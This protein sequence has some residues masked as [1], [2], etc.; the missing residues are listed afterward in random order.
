M[1]IR[2]SSKS[3]VHQTIDVIVDD[4]P[5]AYKMI[6]R[7]D[8]LAK[9]NRYFTIDR[10]HLWLPYKCQP[11]KIKVERKVYMK[12]TINGLND[13]N[14]LVMLSNCILG[15]FFFHTFFGEL[16]AKLSPLANSDKQF[17][18]LHTTQ[19]VDP[20]CTIADDCTK[21]DSNNCTYIVSISNNFSLELTDSYIWTLYFDGSRNKEGESVGCLLIH[22]HGNKIMLAFRLEFN[23]NNNVAEYEALMQGLRKALDLQVKCIEVFGNSKINCT[24]NHL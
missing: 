7:K 23:C 1:M 8:R 24:L 6:L 16:E 12:H 15:N 22:L 14:E 19:I 10:S 13:T 5:E 11:N 3:K 2:F 4:I 18:L 21:V 20:H 9:L 17:E